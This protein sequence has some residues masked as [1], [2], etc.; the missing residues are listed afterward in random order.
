[1][2]NSRSSIQITNIIIICVNGIC[3]VPT[4]ELPRVAREPFSAKNIPAFVIIC[5]GGFGMNVVYLCSQCEGRK[6]MATFNGWQ[7]NRSMIYK[8]NYIICIYIIE[9]M[10][11]CI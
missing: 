2:E 1:M 3:G 9:M 8:Y 7:S 10:H 6:E 4:F 11:I 5:V